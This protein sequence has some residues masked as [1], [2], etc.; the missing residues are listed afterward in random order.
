MPSQEKLGYIRQKCIEANPEIIKRQ[1]VHDYGNVP[2]VRL[3]DVLLAIKHLY[4]RKD[5]FSTSGHV[6]QVVWRWEWW[7]D[8]LT[9]QSEETTDFIYDLLQ[10]AL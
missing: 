1:Y 10:Q 2:P 5:H 9:E 7:K 8:D 6:N 3:A 4:S